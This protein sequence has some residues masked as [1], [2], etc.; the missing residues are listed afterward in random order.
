MKRGVYMDLHFLGTGSAYNP[1]SK[2]TNAFLPLGSTLLLFDCGESTFE[3]LYAKGLLR[4]YTSFIVAVTHFHSDHVGSLGSFISYCHCQL[5][6]QVYLIY[7]NTNICRLLE[8]TGVPDSMYTYLSPT[9]ALPHP[10]LSLVPYEVRHDPMIQCFGYLVQADDRAFFFGG[11]SAGIPV[12]ILQLLEAGKID[13]VYQDV[14]YEHIHDSDCHGTLE[15]LCAQIS[16]DLRGKI[17]CMHFDHD[18]RD[19][20]E[21]AGFRTA[22]VMR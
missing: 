16:A 9:E 4:K 17:V 15:G 11:D 1:L 7:P 2:N 12:P 22:K 19:K 3:T 5:K 14:T 6:K 18:F 21:A 10:G 13:T 20:I 8:F